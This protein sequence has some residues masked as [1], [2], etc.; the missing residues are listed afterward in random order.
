MYRFRPGPPLGP[1]SLLAPSA[2]SSPSALACWARFEK[3]RR[4]H[5]TSALHSPPQSGQPT[6][7]S[8]EG[9]MGVL[10]GAVD[11][12]RGPHLTS[13]RL[14]PPSE[15]LRCTDSDL[16]RPSGRRRISLRP[17]LPHRP[18]LRVGPDLKSSAARIA[19]RLCIR[20]HRAASP[21]GNLMEGG[22]GCWA[23]RSTRIVGPT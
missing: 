17:P 21:R 12:N 19:P 6:G 15:R 10:G 5:R 11:E 23:G 18:H 13:A 4:T 1:P 22:W 14:I 7:K 9:G 16:G 2:A 20:L 8:D 3:F